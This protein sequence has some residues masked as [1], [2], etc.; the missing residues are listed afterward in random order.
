MGRTRLVSQNTSIQKIL[1]S[2]NLWCGVNVSTRF[3]WGG[4]VNEAT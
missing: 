2:L 3:V 4:M 1:R